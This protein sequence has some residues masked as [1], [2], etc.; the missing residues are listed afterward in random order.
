MTGRLPWAGRRLASRVAASPPIEDLL[1][2][3]AARLAGNDEVA[4][5]TYHRVAPPSARPDLSP[6]L[7][8]ATPDQL[9]RH[10]AWLRA[11]A[12]VLSMD[13][14]LRARAGRHVPARAI[15]ITFDDGY[16]DFAEHAWP[17]FRAEGMPVTLFLSTGPPGLGGNHAESPFWWDRL[18]A[19][20][21]RSDVPSIETRLGRIEPRTIRSE[22]ARLSWFTDR[23]K[24]LPHERLLQAVEDIIAVASR[25]PATAMSALTRA[26][27]PRT[28]STP[29][30]LDWTTIR[31][32]AAEGVTIAPHTRTHPLLTRLQPE[33]ARAE[34]E[35]SR[36]DLLQEVPQ[37]ILDVFA[38]PSGAHDDRTG[39]ILEGLGLT[40][41]FTTR[42]GLNRIG[43]T[44]RLALRRFNVGSRSTP[45]WL[46]AQVLAGRL[47]R[48]SRAAVPPRR[49]L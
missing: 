43:R 12:R 38:Y 33:Q 26:P 37:A 6:G 23:L 28:Q 46:A 44:D 7:L 15:L 34:V 10:V 29:V 42:R 9:D 39:M 16:A 20:I 48:P 30:T 25:S 45:V 3:L 27:E 21:A 47:G 41:A 11:R 35:G 18:Y 2:R 17:R 13:E 24:D 14:L 49:V 32:L 4:V 1:G 40:L 8:S 19:A 5:L 31:R 22:P 36:S